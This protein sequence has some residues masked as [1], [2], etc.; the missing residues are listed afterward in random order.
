MARPVYS[1]PI[2]IVAATFISYAVGWAIG[3]PALVPAL[4]T[5][6]SFPFMVLALKRGDPRLAVFRM[7]VWALAMGVTAT[8][9]SYARS[10]QTGLLFLRGPSYRAEMF[11]WV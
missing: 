4:N 8:L 10:A 3:V 6:A 2:F 5:V 7:L 1:V 11:A 9:L